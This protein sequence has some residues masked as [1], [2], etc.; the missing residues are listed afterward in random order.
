[1][2]S[3]QSNGARRPWQ[4]CPKFLAASHVPPNCT[5]LGTSTT[6]PSLSVT[7]VSTP[8]STYVGVW[9]KPLPR[10]RDACPCT[11]DDAKNRRLLIPG[12]GP[13]SA[14]SNRLNPTLIEFPNG[15]SVA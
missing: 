6:F 5:K 8:P 1:M 4:S 12:I 3:V 14:P 15:S 10:N 7:V 9:S 2:S 13:P 11:T